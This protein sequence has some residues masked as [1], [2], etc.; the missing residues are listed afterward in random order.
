MKIM[1]NTPQT[2]DSP[3]PTFGSVFGFFML[4]YFLSMGLITVFAYFFH[5]I[6]A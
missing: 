3:A 5:S 6:W 2:Q 4:T 1:Q